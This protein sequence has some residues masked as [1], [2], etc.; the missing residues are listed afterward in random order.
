MNAPLSV[1]I[2]GDQLLT[3]HPALAAAEA[4]VGRDGVRVVLIESSARLAQQPYQRKKLVLLLSAM[5]HY[6]NELRA[7]GFQVDYR[8]APTFLSGLRDHLAASASAQL[9]TMAA[10]EQPTRELQPSLAPQL[11]LP[12]DLLPNTQFLVGQYDPFP[13]ADPARTPMMATFYKAMRRHF[14]VLLDPDGQPLG[15]KWSYDEANRK[16]LPRTAQP[17]APLSCPPD[18][19]TQAV[20]AEVAAMPNM[21]GTVTGF[22]LPV[23]AAQADQALQSFIHERLAPFGPYEDAMTVR[24][25]MLYHSG[26]SPLL[27]LG[28]LTPL[29]LIHAAEAALTANQAPLNSVE[30]FIRQILGWREYMYWQ[31]WRQLPAL[32]TRNAW[33]ATRP[34][35]AWFW[36]GDTPMR[37]LS[38]TIMTALATGYSH[39]IERLMLLCNFALLAGLQPQAV[40]AWFMAVYVDAYDWV[41]LP[42]VIG[43][44]L[45]A[46]GG[47]IATKPYLASANYINRMSDYCQG[48]RFN[49]KQRTGPDACPFNLLYW[50]FLQTH[51]TTLRANPRLGPAVLGLTR[52]S[53]DERATI[54]H[55]AAAFREQLSCAE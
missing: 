9:V 48:C 20:M 8:R 53:S 31:Y 49:P 23:T 16:P 35:P 43:M 7:A 37:C 42:N 10:A 46:D 15:G 1:W 51:E 45:N 41:M 27:N 11:G 32:R 34:L 54:Q 29:Q 18:P 19:I 39:H 26:L 25:R 2:L 13:H 6:A 36:S 14:R 22:D 21:V 12:V 38:H 44:G 28:L 40:N 17:P 50:D 52:L 33:Q 55:E 30:G 4:Q 3:H 24:S 47:R 5:R